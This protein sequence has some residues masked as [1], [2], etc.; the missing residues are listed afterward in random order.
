MVNWPVAKFPALS[1]T[2]TVNV[3]VP[4]VVGVP[5]TRPGDACTNRPGGRVPPTCDQVHG[6]SPPPGNRPVSYGTPTRP[7]GSWSLPLV[8]TRGLAGS[9]VSVNVFLAVLP[10]PSLARTVNVV[11]CTR[12]ATPVTAVVRVSRRSSPANLRPSGTV[13]L[14]SDH[15]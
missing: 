3:K 15:L 7:L 2:R 11:V 9:T 13:P 8:I 6:G 10:A 12:V 1:S 14:M 4:V 5:L